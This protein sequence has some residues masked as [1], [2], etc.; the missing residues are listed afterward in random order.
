ME[1]M[2][3]RGIIWIG[4]KERDWYTTKPRELGVFL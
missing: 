2:G 3:S 4:S 1:T